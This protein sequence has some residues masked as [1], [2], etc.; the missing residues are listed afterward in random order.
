MKT[1]VWLSL[2]LT[3]LL[4]HLVLL[5]GLSLSM[6]LAAVSD[7]PSFA[8]RTVWLPPAAEAPPR[9]TARVR[10]IPVK[11]KAPPRRAMPQ[12]Q[13]EAATPALASVSPQPDRI[14]TAATEA[15][16]EP[17]A[18][19]EPATELLAEAPADAA[20]APTPESPKPEP[21]P[22]APPAAEP[23]PAPAAS[24]ADQHFRTEALPGSVK[25][26]YRVEANK[27]P[28]TL[29]SE[30][31]WQQQGEN[32]QARLSISAFGQSR[33]QTSRGLITRL[34]LAPVRFG[35]KYRSEVA[36]HFDHERQLV[37]FSANTPDVALQPG[38][39]DRL[40]VLVQLAA[41]VASAPEN[42]PPGTRLRVQ[43]IG[44]REGDVWLFSFG[45][46]EPLDLPG[47]AQTGLKLVRQ[48]RQTYDQKVEVWLAPGLGYLPARIRITETNGDYVDQKWQA[49]E[50]ADAP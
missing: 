2:S 15:P 48:P 7:H 47:G 24:A 18:S 43:T 5:Q 30:L 29:S 8:T 9:D 45:E 28:Y 26:H 12:P 46:A 50:V 25:L 40:S 37:T 49:T 33:V 6:P 17:A 32:Y 19:T 13:A 34:G 4:V 35:D 27:F 1:R 21:H 11:P 3:V 41:L 44:P 16:A 22:P 10:T 38:A 23:A 42:F 36:A 31:L 14:D 39:Q 20:S